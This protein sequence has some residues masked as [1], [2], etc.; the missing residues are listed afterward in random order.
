MGAG[1]QIDRTYD[2]GKMRDT[3]KEALTQQ[4][5]GPEDHRCF[6]GVHAEQAASREAAVRQG[7]QERRARDQA[8]FRR[9]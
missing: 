3:L 8:A 7:R 4:R 9:R 5:A 2:V 6:V 1:R